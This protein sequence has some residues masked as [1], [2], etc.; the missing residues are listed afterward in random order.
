M[1]A[2]ASKALRDAWRERT[3]SVFAV[4]TITA[5]VAALLALLGSYAILTRE[6]NRGYLATNPASAILHTDAIDEHM[7]ATVLADPEV[8]AAEARRT[9]FGRIKTGPAQWH[10]LALFVIPN[11]GDIRLNKFVPE[12]G[13][14]PPAT[15]EVLIERDAM[16]VARTWIGDTITFRVA[17]GQPQTLRVSGRVH[18]VGQA[19]AR[20]ENAVYGYITVDTLAE[21]TG[22]SSLDLLLIQV[23]HDQYNRDH[24]RQVAARVKQRIERE[25]HPVNDVDFPAPGKHPHA[26]LMAGLLL[27]ISS[28]GFFLLVLSGILALNFIAALMAGQIRQIGVMK[29][30]GGTRLQLARIY[31]LQSLVLG[32]VATA[33]ALPL[34][35][36][37]SHVLCD[38]MAGFLNFDITSFSIPVWVFLLVAAAGVAVPLVACIVPLWRAVAIP[39]RR[40]LASSGTPTE[41]FGVGALDRMLAGVGGAARPV[42]LAVRNSFRRRIRLALTCMTLCCAGMFFMAALNLRT[43]M[44]DTFDRLFAATH[45]DLTL[46]LEQ[47]YPTE[48]IDRALRGVPG[49]LASEDWIAGDGWV[50]PH[51][52]TANNGQTPGVPADSQSQTSE[53]AGSRFIVIAMPPDSKLFT[54]VMAQ[55]RRLQPGDT[56]SVVLNPTMAAQNRQIK[57]GDEVRLHIGPVTSQWRVAGICREPM[58]PPAVVYVPLSA[59]AA[60]HPGMANSVQ[61]ELKD[62]KR[63]SLELAREQI[64]PNLEREG[65]RVAGGRSKAEFRYAVDQHVL[66]IYV[67]LVVASCI[68]GGVGG[69]GLMTTMGINILERRREIGILR[70]IGATPTMIFAIVIDEAVTIAVIAWGAAVLLAFPLSGELGTMLGQLLHGG[71]DSRIAPLGIVASLGA[72]AILAILASLVAAGS[73]V[74]L[75]VRE[76]L[77]YE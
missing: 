55:G 12:K 37:G 27:A 21:I 4:V 31:L 72:S 46:E 54:P 14:W 70:A 2:T 33:L 40:A 24:I 23:A 19:Q 39:V 15:G 20:M 77:T 45:C 10:N 51:G 41:T 36:W 59:V 1:T 57:V 16:R 17:D 50:S 63:T 28:F 52:N 13:A 53:K 66:M 65:I 22:K 9:V 75:T 35:I 44:I 69:L 74:R 73:A 48:K 30:L 29:A 38:Y 8:G 76:A 62:S 60:A 64:D 5:G 7:L 67:F 11:Y 71:F 6:L 42:L 34:G 58:L 18:D 47:M 25:G 68:V 49:V 32:G 56:N 43:S 61:I 3:R 26:D